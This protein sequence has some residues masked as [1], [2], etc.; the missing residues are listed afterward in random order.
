M[1]QNAVQN[2]AKTQQKAGISLKLNEFKGESKLYT[3]KQHQPAYVFRL[4]IAERKF[5][6]FLSL[7]SLK[8]LL[9][10]KFLMAQHPKAVRNTQ[11]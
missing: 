11:H 7:I 5:F 1:P 2:L 10:A 6:P 4:Q 8:F 3:P 9:F